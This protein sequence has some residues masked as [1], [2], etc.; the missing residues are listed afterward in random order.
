MLLN[1]FSIKKYFQYVL[2]ADKLKN[3]KPHPQ[4][5]TNIVRRLKISTAGTVYVG[6][7]AIDVQAGRAADVRTIA[8]VG[9]SSSKQEIKK[10]KPDFILK[11]I[12]FL[13]KIL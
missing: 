1:K 3:A 13:K 12:S 9:G 8:V 10:Q 5:I 7:M 6:D 2:C 4:I 11:D